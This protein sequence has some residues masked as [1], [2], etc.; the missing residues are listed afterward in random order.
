MSLAFRNRIWPSTYFLAMLLVAS[1]IL[2]LP[3]NNAIAGM[4]SIC[5]FHHFTGLPCP[6]CGL[7]RS[8]VSMA[9]GRFGEALAWH[10]LGPSLFL[11][12]LIY[13]IWSAWMALK[14]PPFPLPMKL[15]SRLIVSL[16]LLMLGFWALRLAGVFP[17]L[18]G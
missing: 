4:P 15:Q 11:S 1:A 7:T 14:R 10:P 12:A 6:G 2:P 16:S 13:T 8:W 9:H 17:L 18:G 3:H 5:L